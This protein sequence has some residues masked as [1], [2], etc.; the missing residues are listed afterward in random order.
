MATA[1]N[2]APPTDVV[3]NSGMTLA[4]Y[5][6]NGRRFRWRLVKDGRHLATSD[7][8]FASAQEAER[9]AG[10]VREAARRLATG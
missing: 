10:D 4:V 1:T 5:E 8:S 9:A 6:D 2:E 3:S 7:D